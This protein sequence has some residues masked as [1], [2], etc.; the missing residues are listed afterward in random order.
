PCSGPNPTKREH[1]RCMAVLK[2]RFRAAALVNRPPQ[3]S[4]WF[5]DNKSKVFLVP[6][7]EGPGR[8]FYFLVPSEEL[9]KKG[10]LLFAGQKVNETY[11]GKLF[12]FAGG[13]QPQPYAASGPIT[14]NSNTV[15]LIGMAPQVDP[16]SCRIL[17]KQ[18]KTL[19][20]YHPD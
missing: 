4:E 8:Q 19:I 1:M 13:C 20:F 5:V 10:E 2:R 15:T 14:N 17:G 18:E 11:E 12:V 16:K 7:Q 9:R 3:G 6:A